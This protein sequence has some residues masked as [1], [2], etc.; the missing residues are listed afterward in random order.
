MQIELSTKQEAFLALIIA[1][2]A[3]TVVLFNVRATLAYRNN[4]VSVP[5]EFVRGHGWMAADLKFVRLDGNQVEQR[6]GALYVGYGEGDPVS[7]RLSLTDSTV[8]VDNFL[9]N[10]ALAIAAAWV[11]VAM[12]YIGIVNL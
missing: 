4:S 1:I 9:T 5:A 8:R 2:V 10:W 11:A 7:V 6:V 12:A 3:L